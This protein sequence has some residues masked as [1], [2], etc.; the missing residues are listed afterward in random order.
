MIKGVSPAKF[1]KEN[2]IKDRNVN[3]NIPSDLVYLA[4]SH[5]FTQEIVSSHAKL[6]SLNTVLIS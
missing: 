5:L 1:I 4:H 2:L 6:G 3:R